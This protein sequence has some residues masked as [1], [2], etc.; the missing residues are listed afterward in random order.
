MTAEAAYVVVIGET[1]EHEETARVEH[2][3]L[4]MQIRLECVE[5]GLDERRVEMSGCGRFEIIE[6]RH[7]HF[8]GVHVR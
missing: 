8:V 7:E 4:L 6:K 1:N 3:R 5:E 2:V